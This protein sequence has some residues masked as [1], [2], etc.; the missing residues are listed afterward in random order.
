MSCLEG[1]C[2]RLYTYV[3]LFARHLQTL[4]GSGGDS[5]RSTFRQTARP[6]LGP[7]L[8]PATTYTLL[9]KLLKCSCTLWGEA[10]GIKVLKYKTLLT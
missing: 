1:L 5:C 9:S 3:S 10:K 7:S 8:Y 2:Y 6:T 4:H